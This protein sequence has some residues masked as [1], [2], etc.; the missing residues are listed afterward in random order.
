M[1][2][3]RRRE[4]ALEPASMDALVLD[5]LMHEGYKTAADKL[6]EEAGLPKPENMDLVSDRMQV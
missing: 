1:L 6:V 5:F 2:R 4:M 3:K